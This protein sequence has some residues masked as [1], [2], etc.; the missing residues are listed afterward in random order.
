MTK[1]RYFLYDHWLALALA[2]AVGLIYVGPYLAFIVSLGD[3][4]RGIPMMQTA[5][6]DFYMAR[7]QEVVDGHPLIGS[8]SF[9]EYKDQ[10]P[11][12]PPVGEILYALPSIIL[13]A[14]T[15][16]VLTASRFFL[17]AILFFLIY[18]LIRQLTGNENLPA[19]KLNAAA[20]AL[21]VALGYDLIDYRSLINFFTGDQIFTGGFLIW[22]RPVNPILGAVFLFSFLVLVWAI[23]QGTRR[24]KVSI[25]GAA[26][27]LAWMIGSYFFSWGI[28]VSIVGVLILIFLFL[29]KYREAGNLASVLLLG[30][31]FSLPYWYVT[32][33]ASQ[34]PWYESSVLRSGLFYTHYPLMN[35]FLL[36]VLALFAVFLAFDFF[37]K[38]KNGISFHF[39]LW[40]G[41]CVAFILGGLWAYNQQ[42]ITGRTVWPYHFVQYTI[43]LAVVVITTLVFYARPRIA[44]GWHAFIIFVVFS[45]L[46]FGAYTQAFTYRQFYSDYKNLQSQAELFDWLNQQDKD[47]VVLV[48]R[49]TNS[50]HDLN[51]L[52][53]AFTHCGTYNYNWVFSLMP[54]DRIYQSYLVR[55]FFNGVTPETIGGYLKNNRQEAQNYLFSNWKGLYGVKQFPDFSDD[56]LPKRLDK[57]PD[58]YRRFLAQDIGEE[59]KK[60]KLDFILSAGLLPEIVQK[61]LPNIKLAE[62]VNGYFI[63]QF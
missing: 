12:S 58:D 30:F 18:Y 60:Y 61:Q 57:I 34:S 29:K 36:A 55:L 27:F 11:I 3:E 17:P 9:F 38:K 39:Q 47:C 49:Q 19:G 21:W 16:N 1:I 31:L 20:G 6:E 46:A 5:N 8:V 51:G 62:E 10:P 37:W 41:F 25:T 33:R 44:Y 59:L 26:F 43:P 54:D 15:A 32:W 40:H 48:A 22:A 52:I 53:S 42:I 56:I 50:S 7:I 23:I 24:Y 28:A 2:V 13:G 45:S 14:S 63:Y 35:K 4:Y